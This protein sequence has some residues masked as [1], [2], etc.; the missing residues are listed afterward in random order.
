MQ[1]RQHFFLQVC[2]DAALDKGSDKG[3]YMEKLTGKKTFGILIFLL[4]ALSMA[5][6]I[7][8]L[9]RATQDVPQVLPD[10]TPTSPPPTPAAPLPPALVES[11]PP[12]GA[13]LALDQ[14]ITLYFNQ[15]M[16]PDSVQQALSVPEG[17]EG[18]WEWLDDYRLRFTPLRS[19]TPQDELRIEV[20]PQA[21]AANGLALEEPVQVSFQT[22]GFL[23]L[24][25]ALPSPDAQDVDPT[26][27]IVAAFDHPV[28]PL[29]VSSEDLPA[30]LQIEP[31]TAGSGEWINT[32][33]YVFYPE[34]A[35]MGGVSYTV[36]VSPDLT[37]AAGAPLDGTLEW[38]F[39]TARPVVSSVSPVPGASAVRLDTEIVLTFNQ[40]MDPAS[41]EAG[42]LLTGPGGEPVSGTSAWNEEYTQL[43]FTPSALLGRDST[44]HLTLGSS[45]LG[46]GGTPLS[47]P[48]D[49]TFQTVGA[50]AITSSSP[51][52]GGQSEYYAGVSLTFSA[53]I[54]TQDLLSKLTVIPAVPNLDYFWNEDERT[55][56][57]YGDFSPSA[58]YG[59]RIDPSLEDPWGGAL[60]SEYTLLFHTAPLPPGLT[61]TTG[62]NTVFLTPN[63][64]SISMQATNVSSITLELA[65]LP[66]DDLLRMAGSGGFEIL[67]S[68]FPEGATTWSQTLDLPP[69]RSQV[70]PVYLTPDRQPLA[71]GLYFL[72][73]I[74]PP[75]AGE[76]TPYILV[77]GNTHITFKLS[78]EAALVW[79]VDLRSKQPLADAP[80]TLY[81]ED[82]TTL[83]EGRTDADGV[84]KTSIPVQEE[85]FENYFAV[86][87]QPGS[88]EFGLAALNWEQGIASWQ[89]N[90]PTY[91][92]G[93]H[94]QAYLYSDRPIYRPGQTVYFRAVVRRAYN[95]RYELPDTG[96]L[97][98][99][100][101]DERGQILE[102][103]NLS[104]SAFGTAHG[105]INLPESIQPGT[106]SLH[107]PEIDLAYLSFQ[108]AEYRKPEIDLRVSFAEEQAAAGEPLTA[109][110][111]AR[112]FFDA[113]AGSL[114]LRWS[115]YARDSYFALPGYQVGPLDLSWLSANE[116]FFFPD[117]LGELVMEG[118]GQTAPDGTF[119]LELPTGPSQQRR[120]YTLEVTIQD[121]S[122]QPV[123]GRSTIEVNPSD[124]YI[125]LKP[126][127]WTAQAGEMAS[128]EVQ[129]VNWD[130]SPAGAQDLRAVYQKV[131]WRRDDVAN[132][133]MTAPSYT[134]EYTPVASTDFRT[135]EQG[136]ARLA[137]VPPEPGS[138]QITVEGGGARTDILFWVSGEGQALWPSLPNQRLRL[139]AD[140]DTYRP[141]DTAQIFIPNPFEEGATALISIERGTL[142]R[143]EVLPVTGS[144]LD[145]ALPLS[146]EDAPNIFVSI[147]LLSAAE[148]QL[149]FRKGYI[150]LL[151]EPVE[152]SLNVTVTSQPERTGPGGE[153]SFEIQ[154][155]DADGN[156]VQ[157]EFSLAVVDQ[158]VL[159]LADPNSEDILPAFYD[160]QPLGVRTGVALAAY[161]NRLTYQPPGRGG[162]GGGT[163]GPAPVVR[164]EFP[165][166]AF[167]SAEVVTDEDGRAQVSLTLPDNLTTWHVEVRGVTS[168]TRVGQAETRVI[169][170]QPLIV[171]PVA[172]RF[173]VTGDR[174]Q[175][176]AVVQNNTADT[177][178]VSVNLRAT[179]ITLDEASVQQVK[180]GAGD[181]ARVDWWGTV[182]DVGEV[183]L[184]FNAQ[185]G[186]LSDTVRPAGGMIPVLQYTAGQTFRTAGV[187]DEGG[188]VV[189]LVS[190]PQS[191]DIL[192]ANSELQVQLSPSLT[193]ALLDSLEA[194]ERFPYE[195]TELTIAQ[196]LPNIE[197]LRLLEAH[198]LGSADQRA[199]L[200]SSVDDGLRR[201]VSRQNFDGGWGWWP[202]GE[203]D[204][205]ITASA[206]F[207][208]SRAQEA[209]L[210]VPPFTL[211]SAA[212]YL[213]QRIRPPQEDSEVWELDRL[214]FEL[215]A[216]A[217][218]GIVGSGS[219]EEAVA[220]ALYEERDRLSPWANAFLAL[221]FER[222]TPGTAQA[223]TLLSDLGSQA[224]RSATGA[225]WEA[226]D[227][228]SERRHMMTTL[229]NSAIVLYALARQDPGS[230]LVADALRY[231]MSNR[232]ADGAWIS[233][234]STAWTLMA[235]AEVIRG[236]GELG[237]DFAFSASLNGSI[238]ASG[239]AA[240]P[241]ASNPV[242]SAAGLGSLRSDL[243]NTLS[244]AREDGSGR[245][246]YSA[247]LFV[248]RPVED[249]PA[250]S[251]GI[252]V[253]RLYYPVGEAC[254][255][256]C[257]PIQEVQAGDLV[258]VRIS[259]TLPQDV[260]YL[261]LEDYIPAGAEILNASLKTSQLGALEPSPGELRPLY[262][263]RD[264]F[265]DGWGWWLFQDPQVYDDHIAW[266]VDYL[267]AGSYELTYTLVTLQA[268][269]FRV[270]PAQA[271]QLYFPEVQ[272]RS[273]GTLFTILP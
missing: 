256:E 150:E 117:S 175:L 131:T 64:T 113:P 252:S 264:P 250:L 240:G 179:G 9:P 48:L 79:A 204:P 85:L 31:E 139:T 11:D 155:T 114:P 225:H 134:T 258:E 47:E 36:R 138:Y 126:D 2:S 137:F 7:P 157:G 169:T 263:P 27:A 106:Y 182:Q 246:Y 104:L 248:S 83:A 14:P 199:R 97:K 78:A 190:L 73:F 229:S 34:P 216:L 205:Y 227:S 44:Y 108:V 1:V 107:S 147:T 141:G 57:L 228:L 29:G 184:V 110:V 76:I 115:L 145:Y 26:S 243:P 21:R 116:I 191:F 149:D 92:A 67:R 235:L 239:E 103:F 212:D 266:G 22:A 146:S 173:V 84:F 262:D 65:G 75:E 130:Q 230:P 81:R 40:P 90:L 249:L 247:E 45:A 245:L 28:V 144:G 111:Y 50:L 105:Q 82:G 187:L 133:V 91:L 233:S 32:S 74:L 160:E 13:E 43:T 41:V 136:Q 188:E 226:Q 271:H 37:S 87:G 124:F 132:T 20:G 181:S 265:A 261:V 68:Y 194:L 238:L 10:P 39:S 158:A 143:H 120:R 231:L 183:D 127:S 224:V 244:I 102:T 206:I 260:Y 232:Q 171:R 180:V 156:P 198:Q 154:V 196:L 86:V 215:F 200:S 96:A 186:D 176:G 161:G 100:L 88:E 162:G 33:T 80:V 53:P 109:A 220:D 214:A 221:T 55:L 164:Q 254:G 170:T 166:T 6:S 210:D 241:G 172:P 112:Y 62:T 211:S 94:L 207:A 19:F 63:D 259:L 267:P 128:F 217:N 152:Q 159:A 151:V 153:V 59:L 54:N 234:H 167:W 135:N 61:G 121:E 129:L 77:V 118:E 255:R 69:D 123:S 163:P 213:L 272:G 193:A 192:Q 72:R 99:E 49:L 142:L 119:F 185:A 51:P 223:G 122:G 148:G 38:S 268:G 25:H 15:P 273:E 197:S 203:S 168:D 60:G 270:L 178:D 17:V 253:S 202:G 42:L 125:G 177:L 269:D 3:V 222:I 89:F 236:T 98:L 5:C 257:A 218:A 70:V 93:P 101:T 189:E 201:L 35:L 219:E 46:V 24:A 23:K 52:Q 12:Q 174:I 95:G 4:L 209:G 208:L 140:Q 251:Q 165:D 16:D 242:Q 195:S 237:G 71:P 30:A 56:F 8:T 58:T 18:E 66:L